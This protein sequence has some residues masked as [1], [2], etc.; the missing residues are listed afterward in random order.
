MCTYG[1]SDCPHTK[2]FIHTKHVADRIIGSMLSVTYVNK[3][4][5]IYS[6]TSFFFQ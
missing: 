6:S 5:E 4:G 1:V 2:Q 3:N